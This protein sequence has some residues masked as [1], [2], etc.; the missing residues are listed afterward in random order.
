MRVAGVEEPG[1]IGI[2]AA[3]DHLGDQLGPEASAPVLREDVDVREV[4]VRYAEGLDG[5]AEP[6]CRPS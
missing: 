4:H 2:W 1:S 5:P 3:L 6:T